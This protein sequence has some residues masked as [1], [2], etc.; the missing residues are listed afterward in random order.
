MER[1]GQVKRKS[2]GRIQD[3][4]FRGRYLRR[5]QRFF[6]GYLVWAGIVLG[7]LFPTDAARAVEPIIWRDDTQEAFARGEPEGVSL[8][9]DGTVTLAPAIE[10]VA[11]TGEQ[12]VWALAQ[13]REGQV[14]IATGNGGKVFEHKGTGAPDLLFDSPEVA[15]FSLAVGP[16]GALY[17]GSS[18]DGLI[19][20]ISPNRD[21]I[22]F[23]RTGDAHV[24]ALC[25][26]G[27][28]GLYAATGG[29]QGRIL[30]VSAS[31][32]ANQIYQT[33]DHN[34]VCLLRGPDG[35]LY[36]G[37]DENG[38]VYRVSP[39]GKTEVLYDAPEKEIH[40]LTLGPD[41]MLYA[42]AMSG[43]AQAGGGK[44]GAPQPPQPSAQVGPTQVQCV[45]GLPPGRQQHEGR[46][47]DRPGTARVAA[48]PD[49]GSDHR[50]D[51]S[52][53]RRHRHACGAARARVATDG[54]GRARDPAPALSGD[55]TRFPRIGW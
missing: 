54:R 38:L 10:E 37:T 3:S 30:R 1:V 50:F 45:H 52:T 51:R 16:D 14:Y 33:P 2:E 42:G 26:D 18:P 22:T 12:F 55:A 32:E 4:G 48:A 23:C 47:A 11:D 25:T 9:W 21:A 13:G 43:S 24:W 53:A 6:C 27:A 29:K 7:C 31:G 49:A 20:R 36:A 19:Y 44:P 15:I 41:G 5:P 46:A 8:T 17:A 35:G 40:A 34:V 28:G 39:A